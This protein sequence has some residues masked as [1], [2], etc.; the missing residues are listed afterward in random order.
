[1]PKDLPTF[2]KTTSL[3]QATFGFE[4]QSQ[5]PEIRRLVRVLDEAIRVLHNRIND[6][7]GKDGSATLS[8][9]GTDYVFRNG[10]LVETIP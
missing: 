7:N 3:K 5:D 6:L 1:M 8:S 4:F 2:S 9:G 10:I